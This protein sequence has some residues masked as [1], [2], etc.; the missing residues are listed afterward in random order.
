MQIKKNGLDSWRVTLPETGINVMTPL[1][2]PKKEQ[3]EPVLPETGLLFLTPG[4]AV[5]AGRLACAQN[6]RQYF[7]YN[8]KLFVVPEQK[9]SPSFFVAGPAVGAPMAVMALEKLAVLGAKNII[10]YGWCGSLG[11]SLRT[12]DILL[13][14]WALSEEGTS[15]HYPVAGGA[16]SSQRIRADLDTVFSR[17]DIKTLH[18]PI[19]T[20]DAPYRETQYKIRKY[21]ELGILGVD[22]EFSA[23]CTV[24]AFRGVDL[25]AALLVSDE[26]WG[27]T[28]K[29]GYKDK[30]F[31]K[32][33]RT[34]V[35][36][37]FEY[38]QTVLPASK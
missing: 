4:E 38:F 5:H 19:W 21:S 24:A 28:W 18:G 10:I 31:K 36:M 35:H 33:N 11:N 7:F 8:S 3:G 12:G 37:L 9:E 6:A 20:T 27:D 16:E 13:P 29:P 25:A 34:T 2:D 22:M 15:K 14:T 17:S 32:K 1:V 23:L 26:L 30:L